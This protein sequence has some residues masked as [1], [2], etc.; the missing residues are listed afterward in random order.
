MA[1]EFTIRKWEEN[2]INSLV[3]YADN[4]NIAQYLN[5]AFPHPYIVD[6]GKGFIQSASEKKD[7]P[8]IFAIE[9][10]GEAIGGIG[11]HPCEDISR[12][13]AEIGFW[14]G[15]PYWN[16][17]I[18]SASIRQMIEYSFANFDIERIFGRVFGKNI[19]SQKVLE[20]A[21]FQQEAFFQKTFFKNG[22]YDDEIIYAI[23]KK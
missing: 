6:A 20:K 4:Y 8:N 1:M 2:D 19:A 13:N 18:I 15:E 12:K 7:K 14:L 17:G 5:D 3:K 21:E 9:V 11:I 23:R 16:K 22:L 10:K